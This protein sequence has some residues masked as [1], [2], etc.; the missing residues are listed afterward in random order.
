[1]ALEKLKLLTV[2]QCPHSTLLAELTSQFLTSNIDSTIKQLYFI[3]STDGFPLQ[4]FQDLLPPQDNQQIY[5]NVRIMTCLE[6]DELKIIL[7]KLIQTVN[8]SRIDC[9]KNKTA[10]KSSVL[11][12]INGL[13]VM[14]RNSMIKNT[15]TAHSLLN[16]LLLRLR[17]IANDE[18]GRDFKTLLVFPKRELNSILDST[19]GRPIKKPRTA[20]YISGNSIG[21]YVAKFYADQVM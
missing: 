14:F 1:M 9:R 2:W 12:V 19:G 10:S 20:V 5:D 17:M 11:V 7:G 4:E 16:E 15:Q 6:M 13:D 18:D 3:D 8:L 21:E